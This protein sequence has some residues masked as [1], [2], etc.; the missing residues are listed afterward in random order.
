[1]AEERLQ[2]A[3]ARAGYGSRRTSEELIAEGKVR[4]NGRT[5][6]LGDKIDVTRDEVTLG[7]TRVNLDPEARYLVL[8]KPP[9]VLTTMRDQRGRA[10]IRSFLPADG[11][12]VFPVGRLDRD[13]EGLLLLTNDGELAERLTHPRYGIE[14]EYLAEVAAT[15]TPKHLGGVRA[16]VMLEDGPARA[17]SVRLVDAR[18]GR[19]QVAVVMTEGRKREVRRLLAAVG[20]PVTRLVR[21]RI[22][23]IHLGRLKPGERRDLTAD[24]LLGLQRAAAEAERRARRTSR[25]G[26]QPPS[27][28]L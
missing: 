25:G 11:P 9:G 7:G 15:P 17:K 16:G 10:D 22:G 3:L 8:N 27:S 4:V 2:R 21:V 12:R 5:A 28:G 19:G 18:P 13:S 14:K 23:P 26:G 1:M 20:L 24:E 6:T